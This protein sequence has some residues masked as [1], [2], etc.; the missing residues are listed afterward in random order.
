V[1]L[2]VVLAPR[3]K[4]V[5]TAF[6]E[7]VHRLPEIIHLPTGAGNASDISRVMRLWRNVLSQK[8]ESVGTPRF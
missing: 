3:L 6:W 7:A 1:T 5:R 2:R 8:L 4:L